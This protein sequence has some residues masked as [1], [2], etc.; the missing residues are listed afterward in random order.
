MPNIGVSKVRKDNKAGKI[1]RKIGLVSLLLI[2]AILFGLSRIPDP[3]LI[4]EQEKVQQ[5]SETGLPTETDLAQAGE[6]PALTL[7]HNRVELTKSLE[8]YAKVYSERTGLTVQVI[9]ISGGTDYQQELEARFSAGEIPAIFLLD[10]PDDL[11]TWQNKLVDLTAESWVRDT[12]LAYRDESA[13]VVGFPIAAEGFGLVYNLD[14]LAQAGIDPAQIKNFTALQTACTVL[15]KQ[16][17]QLGIDAIFALSVAHEQ[18]MDWLSSAMNFNAYLSGGLSYGN[19]VVLDEVLAGTAE[20]A[21][22]NQY[23]RF[24]D[25]MFKNSV[26]QLLTQGS[27]ADQVT[28]FAEGRAVMTQDSQWLDAM[29]AAQ[30]A[31]FARGFLPLPAFL[32]DTNGVFVESSSWFVIPAGTPYENQARQFLN[33]LVGTPEG[34]AFLSGDGSQVP[35]FRSS[36]NPPTTPL[37]KN[38]WQ[39]IQAGKIYSD[40]RNQ[41]PPEFISDRLSPLYENYA[42]GG[43]SSTQFGA[44]LESAIRSLNPDAP[45]AKDNAIKTPKPA[46]PKPSETTTGE[47]SGPLASA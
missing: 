20:P 25:L 31:D 29:L 34:Q 33:D 2:A 8:A 10:N 32:P 24:A 16:K 39:W 11:A 35:A 26:P 28:A 38:L 21:R 30:G 17:N 23:V 15:N 4:L 41:L 42:K 37:A 5:G 9:E 27:Y 36:A 19:R 7:V 43:L 40:W 46:T 12:D 47:T 44:E 45:P 14:L 1:W 22:L 18:G 13:R 6:A 3:N